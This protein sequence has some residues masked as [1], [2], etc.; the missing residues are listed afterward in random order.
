MI[1]PSW[2]RAWWAALLSAH[3]ANVREA[4]AIRRDA[5]AQRARMQV[6]TRGPARRFVLHEDAAP[7][8]SR[9]ADAGWRG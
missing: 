6:A 9:E 3:A 2:F 4:E 8:P 1:A 7:C 5:E